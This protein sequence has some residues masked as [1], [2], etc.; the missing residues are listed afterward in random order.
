MIVQ[1]PPTEIFT[2]DHLETLLKIH[3][4]KNV[5]SAGP[6]REPLMPSPQTKCP[7]RTFILPQK[8]HASD[9]NVLL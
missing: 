9:S 7:K 5:L 8:Y 4:P 1:E 3:R 6:L 2:F